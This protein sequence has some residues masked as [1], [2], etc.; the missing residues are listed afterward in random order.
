MIFSET[1]SELQKKWQNLVRFLESRPRALVAFSGGVDS[2]FLLKAAVLPP[3]NM[4]LAVIADSASLPRRELEE[5]T[6]FLKEHSI[7]YRI[8]NVFEQKNQDYQK[9]NTNRCYFCKTELYTALG[10]LK[11]ELQYDYIFDGTNKDDLSGHRPGHKAASEL[12]VI[13]PLVEAELK[14]DEIRKLSLK[15]GLNTHDKPAMACLASRIP[16]GTEVT[17]KRLTQVEKAED[18]LISLGFKQVRVRY[19]EQGQ[20]ARIELDEVEISRAFEKSNRQAITAKFSELGFK[21]SSIDLSGYQTGS[22]N[23]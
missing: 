7:N 9:N 18:F 4:V 13:S 5:A 23:S 15:L 10:Q 6:A 3:S 16:Y 22:L 14:K 19:H 21:W 1:E 11:D 2:S 17:E 8:I 12:Q 20:L